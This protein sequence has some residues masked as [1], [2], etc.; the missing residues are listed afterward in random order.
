M[1][2]PNLSKELKEVTRSV[3]PGFQSSFIF[4]AFLR[5]LSE[6][7]SALGGSLRVCVCVCWHRSEERLHSQRWQ[8]TQQEDR[9]IRGE[10]SQDILMQ[11][12][13]FYSDIFT[14]KCMAFVLAAA[15]EKMFLSQFLC[16]VHHGGSRLQRWRKQNWTSTL[17]SIRRPM[18]RKKLATSCL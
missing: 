8:K 10:V 9:D 4:R 12:S 17:L 6:G 18:C 7:D 13:T 1:I 2:H 16:C 14:Y 5:W 11:D 3:H 15:M